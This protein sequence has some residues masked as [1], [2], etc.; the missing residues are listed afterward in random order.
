MRWR[1]IVAK[2][3]AYLL[4]KGVPDAQV[5]AE[6]LAARLLRCGRGMLAG[7]LEEEAPEKYLAAMRRA[8]ARLVKGEP[9]QYVLGEWDFR[10]LTLACEHGG[11]GGDGVNAG[12]GERRAVLD[13]HFIPAV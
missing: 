8:L 4:A 1:E 2:A 10:T 9:L 7:R 3:A 13:I 6:L 12:V 5:A 11:T